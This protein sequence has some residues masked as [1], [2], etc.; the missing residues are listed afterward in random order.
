[1]VR[2]ILTRIGRETCAS[3]WSQ[4]SRIASGTAAGDTQSYTYD[5]FCNLTAITH[6]PAGGSPQTRTISTV[7]ATNRLSMA[8]Y[9]DRGNVTGWAGN[10]YTYDALGS[11]SQMNGGQWTYLYNANDQRV[12]VLTNDSPQ[13]ERYAIRGPGGRVMREL[14][15]TGAYTSANL[16]WVQDYVYAG[17]RLIGSD[18]AANGVRHYH[19]DHLGSL[20][21]VTDSA[22]QVVGEHTYLPYGEEV[23][24]STADGEAYRYT[25]HA[26]DENYSGTDDDLDYMMARYYSPHLG[27]FF[28]VD[29]LKGKAEDPQS[30]N[31]YA[32]VHGNPMIF[33][34]LD[35][36]TK[37]HFQEVQE[38]G[39]T[40]FDN[41]TV[42]GTGVDENYLFGVRHGWYDPLNILPSYGQGGGG[43]T[44]G[45]GNVPSATPPPQWVNPTGGCIRNDSEGRGGFGEPRDGGARSHA[46][47]D[48]LATP[49]Q[50]VL[51]PVAGTIVRQVN[52]VY[53]FDS[54]QPH[55][56]LYTGVDLLTQNGLYTRLF[57]VSLDTSLIGTQVT[58]GQVLGTAEDLHLRHDPAMLNHVHVEVRIGHRKGK[59]IDPVTVI[60]VPS[61]CP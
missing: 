36:R 3:D 47:T 16:S 46:G 13:R 11:M 25:V 32:Y 45:H 26:R 17:G 51:A 19:R 38:E 6:T 57:Y 1:M 2:D 59:P 48:F 60:P 20:R 31:R 7:A 49:G 30:L 15:A 50:D 58:A 14:E 40:F 27:R 37:D 56:P 34:D 4:E 8:A 23:A 41:I 39:G 42:T 29:E 54:S 43:G 53:P 21:L 35:G 28:Q 12:A 61:N 52:A 24:G 33:L 10:S 22:G 9:D 55:L 18:S 5:G 44:S